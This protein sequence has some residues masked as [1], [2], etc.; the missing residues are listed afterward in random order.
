VPAGARELAQDRRDQP[1][2]RGRRHRAGEQPQ[3]GAAGR[4]QVLA[5]GAEEGQGLVAAALIAFADG[6]AR[7][8]GIVQRQDVGLGE[9][10]R[11]AEA[12]RVAQIAFDLDRPAVLNLHQ[13]AAAMAVEVQRR[14]IGDRGIGIFAPVADRLGVERRDGR[15]GAAA[16]TPGGHR[17]G[18]ELEQGAPV[19]QR[20]RRRGLAGQRLAGLVGKLLKRLPNFWISAHAVTCGRW[21]SR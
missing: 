15:L 12:G 4:S 9:H 10:V 7:A 14:G 18:D 11:G 5:K 2:Q 6:A 19:G 13:H 21:N 1:A 3:A 8:V 17:C 16:Q 20:P